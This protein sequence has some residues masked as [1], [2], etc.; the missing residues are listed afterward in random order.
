MAVSGG[1]DS[2]T[3]L[4]LLGRRQRI[5]VPS[6]RVEAV[7]VR[8][9]EVDYM[10]D[11]QYLQD[12][13][14][15]LGVP[16]HV[17]EV[18]FASDYHGRPKPVC[19]ICSTVRRSVIFNLAQELGCNKI[20]FGHHQDDIIRTALMNLTFQG[21]FST[22]PARLQMRKMPLTLIRP[23]CAVPEAL[24]REWADEQGYRPQAKRCPHETETTRTAIHRVFDE[25]ERL[26]P[27]AR[28]S[29]WRALVDAGKLEE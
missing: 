25:M 6:I 11:T 12:F 13:A 1:K 9:R 18:S 20:A 7:H 14:D 2:L 5:H 3:L 22:M 23:L 16:L 15:R 28:N 8:M 26:S 27:D 17:R 19:F 29:V 21:H 24:I 10:T 4:E